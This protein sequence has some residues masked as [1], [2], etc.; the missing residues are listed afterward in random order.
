MG[1][2]VSPQGDVYSYGVLLLE[3]FT[4]KRPTNIM[5]TDNLSLRSYVSIA[6]SQNVMEIVDSRIIM[7]SEDG[8]T[9][10]Q[11]N[12]S[13]N[14]SIMEACLT[15]ILQIGILCCS[16]RPTERM[17]IKDVFVELTVIRNVLLGVTRQRG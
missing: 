3:M 1:V 10:T 13:S 11:Y 12:S 5:F 6:L 8:S 9:T 15:S 4:G 7:E 2:E 16:E 17:D 14:I